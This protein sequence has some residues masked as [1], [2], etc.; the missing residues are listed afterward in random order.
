MKKYIIIIFTLVVISNLP[1]FNFFLQESYTY[2][3]ED[4][5]FSY[6]EEPGKGTSFWGC[7]RQFGRFLCLHPEKE[8]GDN[9]IYRTFTIKPWR[10]WLWREMIFHNERF[11]LPYKEPTIRK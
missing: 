3:N 6:I 8:I 2:T 1:F 5:T 4:N 9:L 7:Q 11:M 10:F